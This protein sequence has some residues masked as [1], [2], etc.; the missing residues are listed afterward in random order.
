MELDLSHL[1]ACL[2]ATFASQV[3]TRRQQIGC[4]PREYLMA[5]IFFST[6]VLSKLK[7]PFLIG[8]LERAKVLCPPATSQAAIQTGTCCH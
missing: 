1:C 2:R 6:L 4:T 7:W 5:Q 3:Q 8:D